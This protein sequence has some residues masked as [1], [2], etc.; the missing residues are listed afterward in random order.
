MTPPIF[1]TCSTDS[2][3]LGIFGSDPVRLF[4]WGLAPQG[5]AKPYA[6]WQ[7]ITGSPENYI[8]NLPDMDQFTVQVDVYAQT[9]ADAR[10]GAQALRDAIEPV[11]HVVGW[12]G[13]SR[14]PETQLYRYSFDVDWFVSR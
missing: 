4:G 7:V 13:E 12:R 10:E 2:T 1:D 8:T 11:A 14:E 6:V 3:V 5:V 9:A